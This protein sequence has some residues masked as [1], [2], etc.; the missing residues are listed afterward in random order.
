MSM[1]WQD[2]RLAARALRGSPGTS[3]VAV[4]TLGLGIGALTAVFSWTRAL[5]LRPYAFE[6]LERLVTVWER[7][8]QQG[9]SPGHEAR[10][11]S[12]DRNPLAPADFLDLRRES[13][14]VRQLSAY[15]YRDFNVTGQGDPE[16]VQGAQVTPDFFETLG[17]SATRGRIFLPQEGEAGRDKVVL[18]SDGFWR[19]RLAADPGVLG[20]DITLNDGT[21]TI[22]GV[23]PSGFSF[24]LGGV[25][26]WAPLA[27]PDDLAAQRTTLS[28]RVVGR[29]SASASLGV[30]QA[31]MDTLGG[32][33]ERLHP[34][35]NSGRGV[36]LVPLRE[37]QVGVVRP[38][39]LVFH[40]AAAFVLLIA[41]ANVGSVLLAGAANRQREMAVRTALGA[42]RFRVVRLI[43]A[44]SALLSLLGAGV[45]VMVAR[46]GVDAIRTSLAPDIVKWIPGWQEIRVD[47]ATLGFCLLVTLLTALVSGLVPALQAS[48]ADVTRTLRDGGRGSTPGRRRLRRLVVV[49]ELTLALVLTAG[50]ALMV[51]GFTRLTNL[52]QGLDPAGV[53]TLSLRLPEWRYGEP[54]EIATFYQRLLEQL[55]TIPGL[56]SAAV[57][58]QLPA[59]LG[60]TPGGGFTI[61]GRPSATSQETPY[62][63]HQTVS[64]EYFRGL[65]ISL[66]KGRL[67]GEQDG[68]DAPRVVLASES[69]AQRFWP[70]EDPTG[71]RV[72]LGGPEAPNPWLTVVGVVADVKQYWFDRE[73]RPTLY[74]SYLQVPRRNMNVVLRTA[75][76]PEGLAAPVRSHIR[77]LDGSQP[78]DEVRTMERVVAESTA[79]IRTA[80]ALLVTLA[81]VA[82][83]LGAVGVYGL[84][85]HHVAQR[86]NEIGVR[87]ALGARREDVLRLVLGQAFKLVSIGIAVGVPAAFALGRVL[88][89]A[90]FGVVG[91]DPTS[92]AA[93]TL[94]LAAVALLGGYVPARRAAAL[95]PTVA[96]REG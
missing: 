20:K 95:D 69:L 91:S 32:H 92:L 65:R 41:C 62:A 16:R 67:L 96:L 79:F 76:D 74:L 47:Q 49:S 59:D 84:L 28:L 27:F 51:K 6:D 26:I 70:G 87:M 66:L 94:L 5:L 63:D 55:H 90:L 31:E 17:I 40:G 1:L 71:R 25:E 2:L 36:T 35:T 46:T 14:S 12:G 45:A 8:P 21:Y 48:S 56:E 83:L 68:T 43:L 57:V 82:C 10:S 78:V 22:V 30:A 52:Y 34:Q 88:S 24:P 73:P 33:L 11:A 38:F 81:V 85:A 37:Q 61:E 54:H 89:S 93:I 80:A 42:S 4:V 19:W 13:R 3:A 39:L 64:S 44:E 72:K 15:R 50:A 86:R 60:P 9:R 18:V 53:L 75:G 58:S 7:H 29:L 23:L 77:E